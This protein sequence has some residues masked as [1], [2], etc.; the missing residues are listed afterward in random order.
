VGFQERDDLVEFPVLVE[1]GGF[2]SQAVEGR[3]L[4]PFRF[5]GGG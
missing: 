4:G 1:E 3:E 5:L 2:F